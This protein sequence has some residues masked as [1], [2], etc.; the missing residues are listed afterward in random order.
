MNAY[1]EGYLAGYQFGDIAPDPTY[2]GEQLREYWRGFE[3]G[4]IDAAMGVFTDGARNERQPSST[5]NKTAE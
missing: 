4:E 2:R 5:D 3:Q 1:R